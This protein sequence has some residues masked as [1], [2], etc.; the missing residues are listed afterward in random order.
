MNT[1][2]YIVR[3]SLNPFLKS[4]IETAL[5]SST[6]GDGT[7]LDRNYTVADIAPDALALMTADCERFQSEYAEL[8]EK[9]SL[10]SSAGHNFWLTRNRHGA[11]F[12]DLGLGA[13]GDQL[14]EAANLEGSCDLYVGDDGMIYAA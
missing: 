14:T 12:W 1:E 8:L 7:P 9:A 3:Q 11:G 10:G 5:W 2:S 13:I 6:D 4:Y